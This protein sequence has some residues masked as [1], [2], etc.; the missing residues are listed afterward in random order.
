M[1]SKETQTLKVTFCR[2]K[3]SALEASEAMTWFASLFKDNVNTMPVK[4]LY[5][6][7]YKEKQSICKP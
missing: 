1:S 6:K 3:V 7:V 4:C 5:I 2:L